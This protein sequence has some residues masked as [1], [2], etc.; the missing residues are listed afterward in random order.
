MHRRLLSG[1]RTA[2]RLVSWPISRRHSSI[3]SSEIAIGEC[4]E[5][6]LLPISVLILS[7][8]FFTTIVQAKNNAADTIKSKQQAQDKSYYIEVSI[9]KCKLTLFEK[10]PSHSLVPI[11]EYKVGTAAWGLEVIPTGKGFVTRIDFNPYWFPTEYTREIYAQKG[12]TLPAAVQPGDPLNYMG[13]FRYLFRIQ[14]HMEV[15]I[16]SMETITVIVLVRG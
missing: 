1:R 5:I 13:T 9:S 8:C 11:R 7:L 4:N 10:T 16:A 6:C 15:F 2:G 3:N 12:V 14:P